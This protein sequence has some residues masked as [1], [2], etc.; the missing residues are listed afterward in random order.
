MKRIISWLYHKYVNK[1]Y[2]YSK[3]SLEDYLGIQQ[4]LYEQ[5]QDYE[6]NTFEQYR[7]M[8]DQCRLK[9]LIDKLEKENIE[10]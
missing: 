8:E 4:Q 1:P 10:Q 7:F 6:V 5:L 2:D 3:I 9:Y